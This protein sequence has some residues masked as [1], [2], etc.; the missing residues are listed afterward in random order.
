MFKNKKIKTSVNKKPKV[1][2]KK[3]LWLLTWFIAI[4]TVF[5]IWKIII[6][7][8]PLLEIWFDV[9]WWL[10]DNTI[11]LPESKDWKIKILLTGKGWWNHDAPNLTDTLILLGVDKK[12]KTVS[13]FSIPRDLYVKYPHWG[14]WKLNEV[15]YRWLNFYDWDESKAMQDLIDKVKQI[16][17]EEINYYANIDFDWF[18]KII[19]SLWWIEVNVPEKLRD[20]A[21]PDWNY[22]YEVFEI[23][24]GLQTLDWETALKYARSRHSTS[25][26]DRSIR[27]QLIISWIKNK[28]Q[29]MWY[30][31]DSSKIKWLYLTLKENL[32]T[33][34]WIGQIIDLALFAKDIERN[35]IKSFNLNDSCFF[36]I[37]DCMRWWFM[38]YPPRE[39]FWWLSVTLPYW[40]DITDLE[41]YSEIQ[42]YTN[43]IFNYPQIFLDNYKIN[44]FNSTKT[45]W[46]ATY[47][48][49]M[50]LKFWFNIPSEN[51]VWNARDKGYPKTV[52]YYNNLEEDDKTLEALSLFIFWEQIE[53]ESP[54]YSKD[55]DTKIEIIVW[56]DYE[57]LGL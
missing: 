10:D 29:N 31:T 24:A 43:L 22:W 39:N 32:K 55:I 4:I 7:V 53:V 14:Q 36:N 52:I 17:W 15:Y 23:S 27:Q 12:L 25:D 34:M 41:N 21:Y 2:K 13:M 38:Y 46:L 51:S 9:M 40:A 42:K 5:I 20:T 33:N 56:D 35:N 48:A 1:Q 44:V 18:T 45:W 3:F 49:N 19:D 54:L 8:M 37:N 11:N 6:S 47:Y 50:L 57:N 26:F 16:T 30:L 28:I